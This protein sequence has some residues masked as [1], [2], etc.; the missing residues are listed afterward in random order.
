M[1]ICG[2]TTVDNPW[3]YFDRFREWLAW[4]NKHG[5]GSYQIL[6]RIAPTSNKLTEEENALEVERA[7]DDFI[8]ADPTNLFRKVKKKYEGDYYLFDDEDPEE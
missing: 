8:A 4:D 5:Y 6:A 1:Y 3:D 2:L 7:I